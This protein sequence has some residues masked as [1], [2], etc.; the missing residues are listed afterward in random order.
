MNNL[1]Y[2]L[3]D[4]L[5]TSPGDDDDDDDDIGTLLPPSLAAGF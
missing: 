4:G 2:S 1:N 3:M 5:I